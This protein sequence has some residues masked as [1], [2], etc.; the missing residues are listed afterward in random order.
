[1]QV[2]RDSEEYQRCLATAIVALAPIAPHLSAEMW[3]R[4][5]TAAV[6]AGKASDEFDWDKSVFQQVG[7]RVTGISTLLDQLIDES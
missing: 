7:K 6:K 4:L 3:E 2:K 1:L 5:A